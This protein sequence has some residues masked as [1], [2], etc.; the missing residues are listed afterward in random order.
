M[1]ATKKTTRIDNLKGRN[2]FVCPEDFLVDTLMN[3]MKKM[4]VNDIVN[5]INQLDDYQRVGAYF[6]LAETLNK[7]NITKTQVQLNQKLLGNNNDSNDITISIIDNE[8]VAI[9]H[10]EVFTESVKTGKKPKLLKE[11][12]SEIDNSN[13][14]SND[15]N[16]IIEGV[17]NE[18]SMITES[19]ETIENANYEEVKPLLEEQPSKILSFNNLSSKTFPKLRRGNN[20]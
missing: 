20:Y 19:C 1:K 9:Q 2:Q 18:V 16:T 10:E 17:M 13:T 12:T 7:V 11:K 15:S 5:T 6:K 14:T 4:D 8:V 3:I